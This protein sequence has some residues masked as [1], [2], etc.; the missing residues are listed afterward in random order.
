MTILIKDWAYRIVTKC[1]P[2]L[3]TWSI[4]VVLWGILDSA[5]GADFDFMNTEI[6]VD[7]FCICEHDTEA[8]SS[9]WRYATST[10]PKKSMPAVKQCQSYIDCLGVVYHKTHHKTKTLQ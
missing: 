2:K 5:N 4:I 9:Q 6:T 10:K 3:L 1:G 8:Q 7:N